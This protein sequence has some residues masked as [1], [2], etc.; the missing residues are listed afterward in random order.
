MCSNDWLV[1][2]LKL[3]IYL[4]TK[5]LKQKKRDEN[6]NYSI[7]SKGSFSAGSLETLSLSSYLTFMQLVSNAT[8]V[9]ESLITNATLFPF[10]QMIHHDI[11]SGGSL[12]MT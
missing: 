4:F 9:F 3:F 8:V 5:D 11:V 7:A 12:G 1:N 10:H 6:Y 2:L